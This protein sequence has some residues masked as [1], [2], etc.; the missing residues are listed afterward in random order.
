LSGLNRMQRVDGTKKEIM[1]EGNG[2]RRLPKEKK[3]VDIC[4]MLRRNFRVRSEIPWRKKQNG[5]RL[6]QRMHDG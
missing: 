1:T 2:T 5:A 3:K 4:P 6:K